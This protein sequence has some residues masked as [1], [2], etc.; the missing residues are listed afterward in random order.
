MARTIAARSPARLRRAPAEKGFLARGLGA[1]GDGLK[2]A[3]A[4]IAARRRLRIAAICAVLS[5]PLLGGGWLA[6]RHSPLVSVDHVRISGVHGPQ[7][8][9]IELA[10]RQ[11][12]KGMS[13]M[14]AGTGALRS[15][16]SRFPI[17]RDIRAIP[18]FPHSLRIVVTE[19]PPVAALLTAGVRTAVAGDGVVLGPTLLSS[20]LP[21]VADNLAPATGTHLRNPLVLQALTVLGAAPTVL[22]RLATKVYMGPRGL[23]VQM[24]NGLL[25]YFGDAARPLAKWLSLARVLA[26]SH[27]AGAVYVDVRLP[28]RP[29]AGFST[30]D[31]SHSSSE[32]GAAGATGTG[33]SGESAVSAL[34]AGLTAGLPEPTKRATGESEAEQ[35]ANKVA[36]GDEGTS[37]ASSTPAASSETSSEPTTEEPS[38]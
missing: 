29:A 7:A 27:S 1:A 17:V 8:R 4:L 35:E 31:S 25:V 13:T 20:D 3:L 34:A 2:Q 12:A 15:A 26:D 18:S 19:Q 33:A 38:G 11:A 5:M 9:E 22:D 16:V 24:R 6:L 37:G 21:T 32:A 10:L 14:S 23:T 36:P 30:E 28:E